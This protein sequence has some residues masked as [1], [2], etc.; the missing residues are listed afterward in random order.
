[1][2]SIQIPKPALTMYIH[3]RLDYLC[4]PELRFVESMKH[5]IRKQTRSIFINSIFQPFAMREHF[6]R[7]QTMATSLIPPHS[8][9]L[10]SRYQLKHGSN[11]QTDS[12]ATKPAL[13]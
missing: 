1:M 3:Q 7:T 2:R 10:H 13:S 5:E 11:G 6:D 8:E 12:S 4:Q 9:A